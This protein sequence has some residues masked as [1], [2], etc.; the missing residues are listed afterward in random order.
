MPGKSLADRLEGRKLPASYIGP[1]TGPDVRNRWTWQQE[2]ISATEPLPDVP[3]VDIDPADASFDAAGGNGTIQV[4]VT[5]EGQSG[6][7]TV[8]K[9]S[10]DTWLTLVSPTTP[11]TDSGAVIYTAAAN[12]SGSE[13]TGH[14]YINGKTHTVVQSA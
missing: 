10:E 5:G 13:R 1:Y 7:W 4:T 3:P 12:E 11:Q 6:T 2:L 9:D 8:D 14:F